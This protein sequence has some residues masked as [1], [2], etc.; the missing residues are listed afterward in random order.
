MAINAKFYAINA[1]FRGNKSF[2]T[3]SSVRIQFDL[4]HGNM[5]LTLEEWIKH[6]E[7]FL[8]MNV[9]DSDTWDLIYL[10]GLEKEMNV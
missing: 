1:T 7:E 3:K 9:K 6:C 2:G 10:V 4:Q 5:A 8:L